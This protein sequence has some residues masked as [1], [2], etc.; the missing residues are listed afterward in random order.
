[1]TCQTIHIALNFEHSS[2]V[3]CFGQSKEI[4]IKADSRSIKGSILTK[5][6]SGKFFSLE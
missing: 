5:T 6:S 1:M 3:M 2:V 4:L